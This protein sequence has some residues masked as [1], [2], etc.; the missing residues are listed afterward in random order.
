VK[1]ILLDCDPG[2]DDSTA[3]LFAIKSGALHVEAITTVS[4]NLTADRTCAN[5]LKTLELLDVDD[6]PVSQG[7]LHPLVRPFPRDPFS[8]GDD[9]LGN[10][11]LPPP[12]LQ[13]TGSFGPDVIV[14]TVNRYLGEI[15]LVATGPL[16]NVAVA[17]TKDPSL[18][19]KVQR[20]VVIGGAFGF[21]RWAYTYATGD[22]PASEWNIFVDPEAAK[23]VFESGMPITAIGLDVAVHPDINFRPEHIARLEASSRREASY[24]LELIRFVRDRKFESYCVLIDS[25]AIAAAIDPS[26]IETRSIHVGIET[27][28]QL[29]R[30]QTVADI[31]A[32][33]RWTHLPLIDAACD[34]DYP[35]FMNMLI[36]AITA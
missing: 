9:G 1:R 18:A 22:N 3:I 10:T 35:R 4:G 19:K 32:N 5:A 23:M 28:G 31:R 6:I 8:H 21:N 29:T 2:I 30:G 20:L 33:F 27:E 15:T 36:D 16:T 7:T 25:L 26:V 11:A 17:L 34:V 24:L 12:R 14:D 13:P